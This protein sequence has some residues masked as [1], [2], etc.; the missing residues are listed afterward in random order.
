MRPTLLIVDDHAGF[1]SLARRLLSS[2]GF[3]VVGEAADGRAAVAAVCELQ[4]DVVLLDIQLP[5][6]DGFEVLARLQGRPAG[7]AVVLTSTRDRA[8]YGERVDGSGAS[9]FIPKAELS[10]AAMLV[11]LGGGRMG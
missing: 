4:P 5:D 7:P 6:I 3:D 10:G 1:R 2:G 11:V 9:G 8:D